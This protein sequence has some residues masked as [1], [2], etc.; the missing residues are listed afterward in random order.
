LRH[1]KKQKLAPKDAVFSK[2]TNRNQGLTPLR[3]QQILKEDFEEIIITPNVLRNTFIA[4]KL[5]EGKSRE[6]VCRMLGINRLTL[7]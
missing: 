5:L 4:R 1:A 6:E 3:I 2:S 7:T